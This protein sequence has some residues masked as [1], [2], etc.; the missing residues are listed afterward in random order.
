MRGGNMQ[1]CPD[2]IVPLTMVHI[3][4]NT[5]STE[6]YFASRARYLGDNINMKS[7]LDDTGPVQTG[8]KLEKF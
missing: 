6:V 3:I 7:V 1:Y 5:R 2:C 8:G 4:I